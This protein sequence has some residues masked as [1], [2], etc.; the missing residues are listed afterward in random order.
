M[1]LGHKD[2]LNDTLFLSSLGLSGT[3]C[4]ASAD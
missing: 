2:V 1:I 4:P 3:G